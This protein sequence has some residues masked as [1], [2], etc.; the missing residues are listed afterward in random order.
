MKN[1]KKGLLYSMILAAM[2]LMAAEEKTIY[3]NTFA[4]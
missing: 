2:S 4:D 1:Y 3:V